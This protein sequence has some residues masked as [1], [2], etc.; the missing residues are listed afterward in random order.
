MCPS[1]L[2]IRHESF[3]DRKATERALAFKPGW[4]SDPVY[5]GS[6]PAQMKEAL[7][8]RLEDFTEDEWKLIKGSSDF[9]GLNTYT[10]HYVRK[11][12]RPLYGWYY[13]S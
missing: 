6:Y 13:P 9:F 1:Q 8:E 11:S 7:G 12:R 2:T 4:F 3:K 5:L 10:T